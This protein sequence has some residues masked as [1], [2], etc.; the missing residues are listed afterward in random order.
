MMMKSMNKYMISSNINS[1]RYNTKSM[2]FNYYC[3]Y[4]TEIINK[5]N[6][7]SISSISSTSSNQVNKIIKEG[8]NVKS[9]DIINISKIPKS[10][11]E[12]KIDLISA[13]PLKILKLA[14]DEL[15]GESK[16]NRALR[17]IYAG[18][19][20]D[21]GNM[22]SHANNRY[23]RKWKPNVQT[24]RYK[25]EILNAEYKIKVTT[26]AMRCI[27]K[28]GSFDQFI[29]YSKYIDDS[30]LAL[31]LRKEM[32]IKLN[33]ILPKKRNIRTPKLPFALRTKSQV[34]TT[35]DPVINTNLNAATITKQKS[36][37]EIEKKD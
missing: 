20:V 10:A 27:K 12:A 9:N 13:S 6:G 30:T 19:I 25:S 35:K 1:I 17:G 2:M 16:I 37:A 7:S 28:A 31:K 33:G 14:D 8:I 15:V 21:F 24:K 22:R 3:Y 29:L 36:K 18:K 11:R 34:A 23:R 5:T 4:S 26:H 32:V